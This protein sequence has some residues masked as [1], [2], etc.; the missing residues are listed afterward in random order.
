VY[1]IERHAALFD[2]GRDG[3]HDRMRSG[4]GGGDRGS[5]AHVRAM[6]RDPF[7]DVAQRAFR[8]VRMTHRDAHVCAVGDEAPNDPPPEKSRPAK[9]GRR[10]RHRGILHLGA[11]RR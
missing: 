4:D 9:H 1:G 11:P 6:D 5:I 3:I 10:R 7:D 8:G 2:I